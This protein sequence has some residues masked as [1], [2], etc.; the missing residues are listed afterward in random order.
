MTAKAD[1]HDEQRDNRIRT[2]VWRP[3]MTST[4]VKMVLAFC[5]IM[6]FVL[7][8]IIIQISTDLIEARTQY[9]GQGCDTPVCN[10]CTTANK[11]ENRSCTVTVNIPRKTEPGETLYIYYELTNFYQNHRLYVKGLSNSQLKLDTMPTDD[12]GIAKLASDNENNCKYTTTGKDIEGDFS[13][14]KFPEEAPLHPCGLIAHSY[15][16]DIIK[17]SPDSRKLNEMSEEN[18]AWK[19]D[20]Q[21]KFK[22]TEGVPDDHVE[23]QE[24]FPSLAEKGVQDE[25]FINWMRTAVFPNFK[26]LYGKIE[27]PVNE[28]P[29]SF[30][31][32]NNFPVKYFDGKK[33]IFVTTTSLIGGKH[34]KMGWLYLMVGI[35][36]FAMITV[37]YGCDRKNPRDLGDPKY[38]MATID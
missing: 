26:K 7:G 12:A 15:F 16:N 25:H 9:D 37:F 8:L 3:L 36:C 11:N 34:T 13:G 10:S 18:I 38:L 32:Q 20:I 1:A 14:Q 4:N 17:L 29:L 23:I 31:V 30:V 22:K 5:M 27:H 35:G 24:V 33:F 6:Y 28:G 19:T 21:H 2:T